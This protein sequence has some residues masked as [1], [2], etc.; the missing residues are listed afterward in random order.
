MVG[1]LV[2]QRGHLPDTY[3]LA[4]VKQTKLPQH[5]NVA[6]S[7]CCLVIGGIASKHIG[8][9]SLR[10]SRNGD[11]SG[12]SL[13]DVM[14]EESSRERGW[15]KNSAQSLGSYRGNESKAGAR[16]RAGMVRRGG[17]AL[18]LRAAEIKLFSKIERSGREGKTDEE[19]ELVAVTTCNRLHC[20][21]EAKSFA[22]L[23]TCLIVKCVFCIAAAT[24]VNQPA[25][26][27][28]AWSR[29]PGASRK[30][31]GARMR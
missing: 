22:S 28:G 11:R 25:R 27:S 23:K 15:R 8:H 12:A 5:V 1:S 7:V 2:L 31:P 9:S 24:G 3:L 26:A 6:R 18:V 10:D 29:E 20:M 21:F 14:N 4:Q 17:V 19:G 30:E 16:A 13:A